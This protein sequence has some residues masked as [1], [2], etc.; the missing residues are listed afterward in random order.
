MLYQTTMKIK[1][2]KKLDR[3]AFF[4]LSPDKY[5]IF[6]HA[7]KTKNAQLCKDVLTAAKENQ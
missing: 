5:K 3:E 1:T 7:L 4:H 6:K 2:R